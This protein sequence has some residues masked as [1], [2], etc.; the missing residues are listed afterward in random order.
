VHVTE[1][2]LFAVSL[3][4]LIGDEPGKTLA[5]RLSC[6][7]V[8]ARESREFATACN[9][10]AT[11]EKFWGSDLRRDRI[12]VQIFLRAHQKYLILITTLT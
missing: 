3:R 11:H 10:I 2:I 1:P 5:N 8:S 7:R 12:G 4:I 6:A 9:V